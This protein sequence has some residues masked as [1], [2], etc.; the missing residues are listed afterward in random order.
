MHVLYKANSTS[1]GYN[2]V[3]VRVSNNNTCCINGQMGVK[4]NKNDS[5]QLAMETVEYY[6]VQMRLS[7]WTFFKWNPIPVQ[8]FWY[9][10]KQ[11]GARFSCVLIHW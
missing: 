3:L 10:R 6:I 11:S 5:C 9:M 1:I 2:L 4:L 8:I 7:K